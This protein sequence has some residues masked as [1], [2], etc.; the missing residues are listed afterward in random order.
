M[1]DS[2]FFRKPKRGLKVDS[3]N[4]TYAFFEGASNEA[5]Y[6]WWASLTWRLEKWLEVSEFRD[7]SRWLDRLLVTWS[8][9]WNN[10]RFD[11]SHDLKCSRPKHQLFLIVIETDFQCTTIYKNVWSTKEYVCGVEQ[12][13]VLLHQSINQAS[14]ASERVFSR[15]GLSMSPRRSRLQEQT[16][17]MLT[18]LAV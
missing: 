6:Q 11:L 17:E 10:A 2:E 15:A 1:L 9:T 18:F 4:N 3:S 12:L 7:L 5:C 8:L 16:L 14:A 13:S